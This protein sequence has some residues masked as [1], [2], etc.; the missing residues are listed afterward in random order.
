MN[1]NK[2]WEKIFQKDGKVFIEP[3][4]Y[5]GKI[6]EVLKKKGAKNIL[7]L[8]CGSGRHTIFL[9]KKGFSVFG[10]DNSSTGLDMTREWL[11]EEKLS[12]ELRQQEMTEKFPW[13]NNFFDA[14]I[15]VQV[16]HHADIATIKKIISEIERVLKKDGFL[17][18]TVPKLKNQA[19]K[20]KKIEPNTYTP[21]DGPEKGLP[22]HYF[23]ETELENFFLNFKILSIEQDDCD[24]YCLTA[25]KL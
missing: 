9:V 8:G 10:L 7:D 1:N 14:V 20:Y 15:S 16:I 21:L 23:T 13:N 18:V 11:F 12:A 5:M 17:F 2:A 22:H 19:K 24:H 6:V 4:K 25:I 3:H